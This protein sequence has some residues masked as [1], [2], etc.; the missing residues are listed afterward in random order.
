MSTVVLDANFVLLIVFFFVNFLLC[1]KR[2]PIINIIIGIFT[3]S[4]S[5]VYFFPDSNIP[6]NPILSIMLMVVSAIMILING[7]E[8]VKQ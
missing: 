1:I 5:I 2:I 7:L 4:I 8:I 3:I 6:A